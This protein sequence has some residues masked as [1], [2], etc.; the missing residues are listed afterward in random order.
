MG[1]FF[2]DSSIMGRRRSR[3]SIAAAT[4][5]LLM[6]SV[7]GIHTDGK[8]GMFD[9]L[10]SQKRPAAAARDESELPATL[11]SPLRRVRPF[12]DR[13]GATDDTDASPDQEVSPVQTG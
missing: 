13:A 6:T 9:G 10:H 4:A 8:N 7:A 1:Y 12:P 2:I 11:R 5:T 3:I